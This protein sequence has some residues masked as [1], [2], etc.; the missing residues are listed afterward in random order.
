MSGGGPPC[1][2]APL[3]GLDP[4]GLDP[5]ELDPADLAALDQPMH[6]VLVGRHAAAFDRVS[7]VALRRLYRT[8]AEQVS[9]GVPPSGSVLDVGAG[10]G[11][12]LIELARQ[13]PDIHVVGTDPSEDMVGHAERRAAEAGFSVRVDARV[14]AAERLPF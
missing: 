7:G 12:L 3:P 2:A 14:A 11:H 5:A 1:T 8:V 13:R 6:K 9:V 4:A 10:P